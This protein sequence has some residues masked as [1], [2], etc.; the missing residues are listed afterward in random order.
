MEHWINNLRKEPL[1]IL[2]WRAQMC[3]YVEQTYESGNKQMRIIDW[4]EFSKGRFKPDV[5][6]NTY[7]VAIVSNHSHHHGFDGQIEHNT[8]FL[9]DPP[10]K[11]S[12]K[13]E[14]ILNSKL[15]NFRSCNGTRDREDFPKRNIIV[16]Q[17]S[18]LFS[19]HAI[20][21]DYFIDSKMNS[22]YLLVFTRNNSECA[23]LKHALI[24]MTAVNFIPGTFNLLD[25]EKYQNIS[26]L[27]HPFQKKIYVTKD[28]HNHH[29]KFIHST[30]GS[31]AC[32]SNFPHVPGGHF[33]TKYMKLF[34][35][36]RAAITLS[37]CPCRWHRDFFVIYWRDYSTKCR[38]KDHPAD[39]EAKLKKL[40]KGEKLIVIE[41]PHQPCHRNTDFCNDN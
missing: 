14:N 16:K 13:A 9:V 11:N 25:K 26:I 29:L 33:Y 4:T 37:I 24:F 39:I 2:L 27:E 19:V 7:A 6:I 5:K 28:G 20:I 31:E 32:L 18:T 36:D 23:M 34:S 3:S 22:V 38:F 15:L 1:D 30:E 41:E 10:K 17:M 21:S 35:V 12:E 8:F 40:A